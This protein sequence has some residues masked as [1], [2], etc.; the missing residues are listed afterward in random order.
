MA[1]HKF[2]FAEIFPTPG[3]I[4]PRKSFG[5]PGF[6][7]FPEKVSGFSKKPRKWQ[8]MTQKMVVFGDFSRSNSSKKHDLET[9]MGIFRKSPKKC[10]KWPF[11]GFFGKKW[12]KT[13]DTVPLF[14]SSLVAKGLIK[15]GFL[16]FWGFC[17]FGGFARFCQKR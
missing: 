12:Q 8:K 1:R 16:T 3:K 5:G 4:F 6:S 17:G 9:I 11:F 7:G 10:Q 14:S 13:V 15:K 2:P